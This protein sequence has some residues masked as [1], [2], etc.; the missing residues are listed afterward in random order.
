M[1]R[2]RMYMLVIISALLLASAMAKGTVYTFT[3]HVS[4]PTH[5]CTCTCTCGLVK[6][7]FQGNVDACCKCFRYMHMFMC[8]LPG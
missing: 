2:P 8:N 5:T 1:Q 4:V 6:P 7:N 3:S